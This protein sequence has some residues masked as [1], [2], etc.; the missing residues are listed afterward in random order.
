MFLKINKTILV[1]PLDWG[2]GHA[3]RCIPIIRHLAQRGCHI[4]LAAEGKQ[5]ELFRQEFPNIE[6]I[7]LPGYRI[8]YSDNKKYFGWKIIG[9]IPR[10]LKTIKNENQW[11]KKIV[12]ERKIDAVISD[13]R[14]GL[15]HR[16][17]P[18]VFITH[19]LAVKSGMNR[20]VDSI[21]QKIN[22]RYIDRFTECWVP[23]AADRKDLGGELSHPHSLPANTKYIGWLSRMELA[24]TN[25]QYDIACILSG[26][27]PQR[28]IL[29]EKL[30]AQLSHYKGKAIVVRGL[31][32]VK[33]HQQ[34][35]TTA[36]HQIVNHLNAKELNQ[37]MAATDLIICRSG[38]SSVMD[39]VKLQRKAVLIPTPGQT[40]QE[41]LAT[42]LSVKNIFP[43]ML[44]SEFDLEK[45]IQ[46]ST[47]FNYQ[48]P[49]HT[50]EYQKVI[51]SFLERI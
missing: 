9:Q 49:V 6:I 33:A 20:F 46:K 1:A 29:E 43:F 48:F 21:L 45:A 36:P 4:L 22:Y 34:I 5:A 27:E 51:N 31:P 32:N 37:L 24:N 28:T 38:Y 25:K 44:Q 26:P 8:S 18:S 47:N 42:Y 7:S 19:Q 11:L 15:Y 35:I 12:T 40:E 2:L 30:I 14:Y 3:T 17:V 13:N 39:L 16:H 50:D 41:Y 23:D 10:I